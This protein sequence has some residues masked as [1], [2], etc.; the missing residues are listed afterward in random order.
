MPLTQRIFNK[1]IVEIKIP[2]ITD[3]V[4]ATAIKNWI[5]YPCV[6]SFITTPEFKRGTKSSI[7]LK[8]KEAEKRT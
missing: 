4:T 8:I 3:F 5:W 7:D 2:N 1:K 6:T